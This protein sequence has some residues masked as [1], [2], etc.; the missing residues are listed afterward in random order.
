MQ[1]APRRP[2]LRAI[3]AVVV[4]DPEHG[5]AI[6]LRDSE[7]IAPGSVI[8]PSAWAAVLTRLDGS[9]TV[10]QIAREASRATGRAVDPGGVAQLADELDRAWMLEGPRLW[11]RR[12]QVTDEFR[13]AA[14][15]P[16]S[17]AGG[18]YPGGRAELAEFI[19]RRCLEPARTAAAPRRSARRMVGLCAPH[20][21]LWRAAVGYGHAYAALADA[22]A[23]PE[24]EAVETFVL[25]GTCHAPMRRPFTVCDKDFET[26]FGPLPPD[27]A[28]AEELADGSRFDVREDQLL[29][30]NEHSIELQAIFV[31]HLAGD[32]PVAVVPILCGL[33]SCQARRLDPAL[34]A[35]AE[36]FL[37]SLGAAIAR[38]RERVMVIAGADLGHVGP[39]FGDPAPLS[40]S[41]RDAL[42]RRDHRSIARATDLDPGGFFADTVEDLDTR[43]V[44]GVGP[45]YTLLRVMP[46]GASGEVLHY[47]QHVDPDEGSIVTHAS[48]GFYA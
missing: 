21:D 25:L 40:A 16:A 28:I 29:H 3:E 34:D 46:G 14:A 27:R 5:Q 37:R 47:D 36:S 32:R 35:D 24:A 7:G 23:S 1:A 17:H 10:E 41:G 33:S 2:K 20:M 39:R 30:K 11:A 48:I 4:P 31:R 19:E 44:C 15:R 26:P 13:A 6:L 45:I 18:A 8:V 42:R 22:L 38:R 9:R 43:R 12:R